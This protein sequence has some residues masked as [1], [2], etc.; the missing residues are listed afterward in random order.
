MSTTSHNASAILASIAVCGAAHGQESYPSKPVKLVSGTPG[1]IQDILARVLAPELQKNL[2]QVFV[3]E[4]RGGAAGAVA[5]ETVVRAPSDGYTL[6]VAVGAITVLPALNKKLSFDVVRDFSAVTLLASAPNVLA[7]RAES[8]IKD[9]NEFL[10]EAKRKPGELTY[11]TSGIATTVHIGAEL[12]QSLAGIKLFHIPYNGSRPS[13]EALL[14]GQVMSSMSA[15]NASLP[16]I[17][18]GR[19]RAL[20]VS[21]QSRTIFLPD[22][23]TFMELGVKDMKSDTWLGFMG[24]AN[25]PRAVAGRLNTELLQI[26]G[27]PDMREKIINMGSETVGLPLEKFAA[28]IKYE[29][30]LYEK[31]VRSA[32]IKAE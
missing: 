25:L 4:P 10:L 11:A 9:W 5:A 21:G 6:L 8:P 27:R 15:V 20:A 19:L 32:G 26:I 14:G 30:D 13:V 24:P 2:G 28:L 1:G 7:V 22:L 12:L 18:S 16:H 23:P 31:L 29:V 17:K 3:V